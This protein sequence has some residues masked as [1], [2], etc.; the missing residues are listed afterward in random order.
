MNETEIEQRARSLQE[1]LRRHNYRYYVLNDP[2][3]SDY[4]YDQLLRELQ[5]IEAEHP[6]LIT[7]DSPT[8]RAGIAPAEG[9]VRVP[10]PAPILSLAN[11]YND[12][13]LVAWYERIAKLDERVREAEFVVEP[14]LD[15]LTVVLHYENGVFSQGATRGDGEVGEDIT[16]NLRTVRSLPLRIPVA[17]TGP[18]APPRLVVRGE[19]IIYLD[20]FEALNRRLEEAGER[21]Y[22]N[23]RN[24][25]AGALRQL[26]PS[27]TA[28]RPI[29]LLCYAIVEGEGDLPGTQWETLQYLRS[30]G[31][32]VAEGVSLEKDIEGVL[33]AHK[34]WVS[35]RDELPYEADG[36]VVKLN[37]L[38][39]QDSLGVVGKDP[40]GALAYKFPAQVV[41]TDLVDIGLN[42]GRTGVITPYA[43]LD[44]V[45]V[46][47]VTVRQATL[48]N[49][50]FI[51]EKDIRIGDRVQLKRAGD[52]IPYIIG[53]VLE[54][55][56]KGVEPYQL[57]D[58]CP[59]CGE[60]LER[61]EEEVAVYCVNAS[62]PAQLVRNVEHF[63][64]RGAMDI[65]GLGIRVA[66]QLID[67]R[68]IGDVAD[69]YI[70]KP[71]DL[72]ELDGFGEK[73]A[74][75]LI[76]SI[77]A[78]KAQPL[79]R[80]IN[81]LGIRTVGE[82]VA[83]DLAREFGSLEQL[84]NATL[85][86]LEQV[87][88]IGPVVA[89]TIVDWMHTPANQKL[90]E[91]LKASGVWPEED[92]AQKPQVPQTLAGL[93]FVITGTLPT[94]SREEAKEAI[95]RHGGKATGSVSSKTD[96]LV[97]GESPGSKLRKAQELDVA[98]I[99]EENLRK[100]IGSG[101]DRSA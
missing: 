8:Q 39:L 19:A 38:E 30:L 13:E 15:G 59:S 79:P 12:E 17:N 83:G 66:E 56:P 76:E 6:E 54:A 84:S 63:A 97:L 93:T 9:F 55:R 72:L 23:P 90:L 46:G 33:A 20:D 48:H 51:E 96:Y 5:S 89:T 87:E 92:R 94:W 81:G 53:P 4:E 57:P 68:V 88:G 99:D 75:N 14:K 95:E 11:A 80:L 74:E 86:Q 43:I 69:L 67:D 42:V 91:K 16:S 45:E 50:D 7:P 71:D 98:I 40:R 36:I 10:H 64:S 32:P 47:G 18:A 100:L 77:A 60:P 26:D 85:E 21:T 25:A 34:R 28:D 27:L 52:V 41:T 3:V 24:T 101:P 58:H 22:V 44:P 70:L 73:R 35:R 62:C 31:F 29:R 82:T 65:E 78:S 2:V 1:E 37:D 49:F 61:N